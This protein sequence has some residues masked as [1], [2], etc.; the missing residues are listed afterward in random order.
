MIKLSITAMWAALT[1]GACFQPVDPDN[2]PCP[3]GTGYECCAATQTCRPT[4]Q[5]STEN[6]AT[7]AGTDAGI[8]PG[9][10]AGADAGSGLVLAS[11]PMVSDGALPSAA[12]VAQLVEPMQFTTVGESVYVISRR[13]ETCVAWDF[14]D[15]SPVVTRFEFVAGAWVLSWSS[16]LAVSGKEFALHASANGI[17]VVGSGQMTGEPA[18]GGTEAFV[19]RLNLDGSEAWHR[20]FA[21]IF[22]DAAQRVTEADGRVIIAGSTFGSL[23]GSTSQGSRD[24]WVAVMSS[25]GSLEWFSQFG[26]SADEQP[27]GLLT[28]PGGALVVHG[29]TGTASDLFIRRFEADGGTAWARQH[30]VADVGQVIPWGTGFAAGDTDRWSNFARLAAD[31]TLEWSLA[32]AP[33]PQSS[34]SA[35]A[36]LD[37]QRFVIHG[38]QTDEMYMGPGVFPSRRLAEGVLDADGGINVAQLGPWP[39]QIGGLWEPAIVHRP[40]GAWFVAG[41][42]NRGSSIAN[43]FSLTGFEA[44]GGTRLSNFDWRFEDPIYLT[45]N[46]AVG[47]LATAVPVGLRVLPSGAIVTAGRILVNGC[48]PNQGSTSTVGWLWLARVQP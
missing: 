44:T 27:R 4:G 18:R 6:P 5:C 33:L 13:A 40:D 10:D 31:G 35:L 47:S 46:N 38:L 48:N 42:A 15:Y 43:I 21:S 29:S 41:S 37:D 39:V 2:A 3:C 9:T 34:V 45:D 36:A 17:T 30:A 26:S 7:D 24:A 12:M 28:L 11:L 19:V 23:E 16:R 22:D 20:Q 14:S 32:R 25:V 8:D 1:I